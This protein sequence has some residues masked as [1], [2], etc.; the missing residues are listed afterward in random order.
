MELKRFRFSLKIR[1]KY[2]DSSQSLMRSS[3]LACFIR[4]LV[5]SNPGLGQPFSNGTDL[6][7]VFHIFVKNVPTTAAILFIFVLFKQFT[8]L[9][10]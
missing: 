4:K 8:G 9:K 1:K 2:P 7:T 10:L 5:G 6:F 3:H